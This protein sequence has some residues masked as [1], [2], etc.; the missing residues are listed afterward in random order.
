[1]DSL[2]D[3]TP[4]PLTDENQRLVNLK[5]LRLIYQYQEGGVTGL[6]DHLV[7]S[8]KRD[9]DKIILSKDGM[10]KAVKRDRGELTKLAGDGNTE[11]LHRWLKNKKKSSMLQVRI[12]PNQFLLNNIL[13]LLGV[14]FESLFDKDKLPGAADEPGFGADLSDKDAV[15]KEDRKLLLQINDKLD[16]ILL[17]QDR[18]RTY[19]TLKKRFFYLTEYCTLLRWVFINIYEMPSENGFSFQKGEKTQELSADQIY[20]KNY[21]FLLY[22]I[23]KLHRRDKI[24]KLFTDMNTWENNTLEF[25]RLLTPFFM[26]AILLQL[27][28]SLVKAG[29]RNGNDIFQILSGNIFLENFKITKYDNEKILEKLE[30]AHKKTIGIIEH[31]RENDLVVEKKFCNKCEILCVEFF[32]TT[33]DLFGNFMP[34]MK[35]FGNISFNGRTEMEKKIGD[36]FVPG[37]GIAFAIKQEQIDYLDKYV[38]DIEDTQIELGKYYVGN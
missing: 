20:R 18:G 4:L 32:R 19:R 33:E 22:N 37:T 28:T 12:T 10:R 5:L 3:K 31:I 26:T 14:P 25:G 11:E 6:Y 21:L 15:G 36:L 23:D 29:L 17:K 24:H 16:K 7:P 9:G 13:S 38:A 2:S 34:I 27:M 1:M 8:M 30:K 35:I